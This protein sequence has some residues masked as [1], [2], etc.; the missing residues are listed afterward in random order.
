MNKEY[1]KQLHD[2]TC[3][4]CGEKFHLCTLSYPTYIEWVATKEDIEKAKNNL[5][6]KINELEDIGDEERASYIEYVKATP[7]SFKE[8]QE[9]L[10][11]IN[12][13]IKK[14]KT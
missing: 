13:T 10:N 7:I 11:Q 6:E 14:N 8:S 12:D 3:P 9:I 5:I 4:K 2:V 1:T